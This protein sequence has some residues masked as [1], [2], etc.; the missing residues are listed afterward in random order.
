MMR[1]TNSATA[2]QEAKIMSSSREQLVVVLYEHLLANLRRAA[3]QIHRQDIE[4]RSRSLERAS[5]IVFELLSALDLD[6]GGELASRL[7]A[8][9][10]YFIGEISAV[11]RALDLER[12]ERLTA[13]VSTL[14]R[15]WS[16]AAAAMAQG[17]SE[18]PA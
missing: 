9:Y 7:A 3:L 17:T 6:A 4:G 12:L 10:G 15:S 13:I 8:L 1:Q 2:Y 5:D 18:V 16:Q 14:H 11:G